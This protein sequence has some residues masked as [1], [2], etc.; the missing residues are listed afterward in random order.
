M[1]YFTSVGWK[2][3]VEPKC[4]YSRSLLAFTSPSNNEETILFGI[5][6]KNLWQ[7]SKRTGESYILIK[8][9]L[10]IWLD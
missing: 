2:E 6:E 7:K 9:G 8:L 10:T 1:K 5:K 3:A 4:I